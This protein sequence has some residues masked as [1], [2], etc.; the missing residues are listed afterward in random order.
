MSAKIQ[1]PPRG[2]WTRLP[3]EDAYYRSDGLKLTGQAWAAIHYPEK[4]E[5]EFR[6]AIIIDG[7]SF[8]AP[9]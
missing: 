9:T 8:E 1:Q 4:F 3:N 2:V 6:A 7:I 5:P